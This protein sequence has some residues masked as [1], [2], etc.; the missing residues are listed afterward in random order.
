MLTGIVTPSCGTA[1][2]LGYDTW[3]QWSKVQKLIGLCPQ[4]STLYE[5]LTPR[6][7]LFLYGK[8]KGVMNSDDL[9]TDINAFLKSMDMLKLAD[10]A[11]QTISEGMR[12]RLCVALAFIGGSKVVVLDEPTSG[13]DPIARRHIWDL[14]THFKPGRTIIFTTHHLD[15]AELLSDKLAIIHKGSLLATGTMSDLKTQFGGSGFELTVNPKPGFENKFDVVP[16]ILNSVP[17]ATKLPKRHK[18]DTSARFMLP[19]FKTAADDESQN[20]LNQLEVLFAII[21][22]EADQIGIENYTL[23]CTSLEQI[24]LDMER[25][26]AG[27]QAQRLL[28]KVGLKKEQPLPLIEHPDL[29][30]RS[31]F[32]QSS[33]ATTASHGST[34]LIR[35]ELIRGFSLVLNQ[36][37]ALLKK[38]WLHSIRDWRYLLSILVLPAIL[39]A[40][41]LLLGLLKPGDETPPLL[42][43]PSIYGP[44]ENTFIR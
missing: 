7:H 39:L 37:G 28:E 13:V 9:E 43:T 18:T 44:N 5:T 41:S 11:V 34:T 20:D 8:I 29:D 19:L 36:I 25:D 4:Q 1:E 40:I 33:E 14:I 17:N 21:D 31:E 30:A 32:S 6:E 26:A 23:E 10:D 2:I 42:M 22:N 16:H 3:T 27:P 24:F 35:S 38:R 12:R 15:E